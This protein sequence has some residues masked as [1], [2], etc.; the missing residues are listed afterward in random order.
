MALT[1]PPS[2]APFVAISK[3]NF[4]LEVTPGTCC[5]GELSLIGWLRPCTCRENRDC[6][7]MVDELCTT[8]NDSAEREKCKD[9]IGQ[10]AE[11]WPGDN[12]GHLCWGCSH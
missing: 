2:T 11:L 3:H 7:R 4:F 5:F 10:L 12:E 1:S 6:C 9:E 8:L